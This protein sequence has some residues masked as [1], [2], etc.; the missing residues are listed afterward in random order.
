TT[1]SGSISRP[2]LSRFR[3]IEY[4][5]EYNSNELSQL[6]K[7]SASI[8]GLTL[9]DECAKIVAERSR[10]TA[11]IANNY[12]MWIRDYLLYEN[13]PATI[14]SVSF[15]MDKLGIDKNGM[16]LKDKKYIDTLKYKFNGGPVSLN[17]LESA[18]GI[19]SKTI[20]DVIEPFLIKQNILIKTT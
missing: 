13:K 16:T 1:E 10:N 14:E 4:V 9:N 8:L 5:R 6:I 7:R 12:I 19:D 11:R 2:L 20:I 15:G 17:I 3:N 18:T